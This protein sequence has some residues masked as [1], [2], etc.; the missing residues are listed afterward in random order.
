MRVVCEGVISCD[1]D[2]NYGFMELVTDAFSDLGSR[3]G[4]DGQAGRQ[5]GRQVP[6]LARN[7]VRKL[8]DC[9]KI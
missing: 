5:A 2:L 6:T 9:L 3:G 7:S 1:I 4:L 8:N